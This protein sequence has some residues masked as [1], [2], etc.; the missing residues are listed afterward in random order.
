MIHSG[1]RVFSSKEEETKNLLNEILVYRKRLKSD[2]QINNSFPSLTDKLEYSHTFHTM[3][4]S[5]YELIKQDMKD[6]FGEVIIPEVL[7]LTGVN[8]LSLITVQIPL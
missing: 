3:T 6:I 5:E 1:K 7:F 2:I 4:I 8:D